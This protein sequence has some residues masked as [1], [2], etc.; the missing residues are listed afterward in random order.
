LESVSVSRFFGG[1]GRC[2][3]LKCVVGSHQAP[4]FQAK[5]NRL[6]WTTSPKG[7]SNA[8]H[9]RISGLIGE[10][11]GLFFVFLIRLVNMGNINRTRLLHTFLDDV[12]FLL[13][14]PTADS[15]LTAFQIR[16][17]GFPLRLVF[18]KSFTIR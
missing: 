12:Q 6:L 4:S 13:C 17:R 14:R 16:L 10:I 5:K 8:Y 15:P 3:L 1:Q 11:L 9:A 7:P 2:R 18:L